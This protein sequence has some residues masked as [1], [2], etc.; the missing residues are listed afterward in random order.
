MLEVI[1]MVSRIAWGLSI[2]LLGVGVCIVIIIA[3]VI[4]VKAIIENFWY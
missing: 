2:A 1:K 3:I 4:V